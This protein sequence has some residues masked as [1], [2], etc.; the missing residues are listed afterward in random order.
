MTF[1]AA[2]TEGPLNTQNWAALSSYLIIGVGNPEGE[3]KGRIGALFLRTDGEP[4]GT[5]YAKEEGEGT[6]EGWAVF[7]GSK[8]GG[9][10]TV[11][12]LLEEA[13]AREEA[14]ANEA[15]ARSAADSA[16]TTAVN[17]RVKGPG[18]AVDGDIA[19]YDGASGKLIKDGLKTIA[20][21]LA[22]AN[23]TGTQI[24][25]TIS[26]FDTQVRTSRLDQ[27]ATPTA[28]VPW[29][30]KKITK[31]ADPT[32]ALDAANKEYVDAAALAAA[33][34][35]SVKSPVAYATTAN[36]AGFTE[37]STT[38]LE[39]TA[40]LTI[41]GTSSFPVGTRILLKNQ[42]VDKRNGIWE[43]TKSETFGGEGN[44][45]GSGNFGE[46][47]K[48]ELTR[49]AD[50]NTTE[51][52]KQGMFVLVTKGETNANTT[53]I[54]TTENPIEIGVT[55]EVFAAFTSQPVGT[56]GG[57][58]SGTYP[59][60]SIAAG[61]VVNADVNASAAI[62][63]SKLALEATIKTTD[64]AAGNRWYGIV[65]ALPSSPTP[66][67]G[68]RCSYVADKTNGVYWELL[69]DSEGEY[70]WKK[71]GGAPL[72]AEV[73]TSQATESKTYAALA[74]VGPS[75]T[76]PLKGDYDVHIGSSIGNTGASASRMSYD[77]GGTG[78]VDADS[79]FGE[80]AAGVT[81]CLT[82][83]KRKTALAASTA[84]VAKYKVTANAGF[85]SNRWMRVDPVR[86][87]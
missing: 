22:R 75:V 64:M 63:Y 54:L 51:E 13:E 1:P 69:Y 36:I 50:A 29:G 41:D 21:V 28:N 67:K 35:L 24:A 26:D 25:S 74:T 5:V 44:F 57:D 71:I 30:E 19:V 62:A 85:F 8:E 56:A 15:S 46:G 73:S 58:L 42:A 60:P 4:G 53:W 61:A 65:E 12:E 66:S 70:P 83:S 34:G 37:V 72:M 82:R 80:S 68:D 2:T 33:A 52:V 45:G 81:E 55:S 38:V 59:N 47:G 18:S 17:E 14:D 87:G 78:A 79:F 32:E 49:T 39:K 43:V 3:V 40:P 31:L 86:V 77:I 9:F 20:Q 16:L 7:E 23:H 27:M 11:K 84:L 76:V 48:V 6:D 10:V